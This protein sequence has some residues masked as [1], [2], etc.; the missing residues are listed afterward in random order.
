MSTPSTSCSCLVCGVPFP[1]KTQL[2]KHI[3]LKHGYVNPNAK[4]CK[5]GI[6]VGWLSHDLDDVCG[7]EW[8]RDLSQG[9]AEEQHGLLI[10]LNPRRAAVETALFAALYAA[11]SGTSYA[12]AAALPFETIRPKSF[13]RA[14]C[15]SRANDPEGYESSTHGVA[16]LFCILL[17]HP[18]GDEQQWIAKI[19][20]LIPASADVCVLACT[21]LP[22]TGGDFNANACCT[23]LRYEVI[24]PL[25][26][27]IP[28]EC[29]ST[30]PHSERMN[31]ILTALH[32]HFATSQEG[33]DGLPEVARVRQAWQGD[34]N[35]EFPQHT[36]E[37]KLR[38]RY[39]RILKKIMRK[40]GGKYI[41]FHNFVS[42]GCV[43][44]DA[45]SERRVDRFYH[46]ELIEHGG[47]TYVVMSVSGDSFL[48]GQ[49]RRI[50]AVT[51]AVISGIIPVSQIDA[52]LSK[53]IIINL[54]SLPGYHIYLSEA[55]YSNWEARHGATVMLD[56]RRL[57][58]AGPTTDDNGNADADADLDS[59][60]PVRTQNGFMTGIGRGA[61]LDSEQKQ[62]KMEKEE[63]GKISS[64]V[65]HATSSDLETA[66]QPAAALAAERSPD[67]LLRVQQWKKRVQ[68]HVIGMIQAA[69]ARG[70]GGMQDWMDKLRV[71]G[72]ETARQLEVQI[73]LLQ[74]KAN[75][76]AD[77]G[78]LYGP[79]GEDQ[80]ADVPAVYRNVLRLLRQADASGQWP[81]SS[82][83]RERVLLSD[84]LPAVVVEETLPASTKNQGKRKR[85]AG[86]KK[87]QDK[88]VAAPVP[89]VLS[90]QSGEEGD[91]TDA[92]TADTPHSASAKGSGS[93]SVG[94]L[95]AGQHQ[96]KGNALFPEL[97]VACFELERALFPDRA[98]SS[99]V[100]INRH[101]TFKPHRDSGAGNGQSISL[102]VSL[103][104]FT[105]GQLGVEGDVVDIRYQPLVFDGWSQRHWTLPFSGERFSLVWFTPLG[106]DVQ[107]DL[108][109]WGQGAATGEGEGG[110]GGEGKGETTEMDR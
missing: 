83:A 104:R 73:I 98:P 12:E 31:A 41:K 88:M 3:E 107:K 16:D 54:P 40:F 86:G 102:I 77:C 20:G 103:G 26:S 60:A 91:K 8:Q 81:N 29:V 27:L 90:A 62:E 64:E 33:G 55:K 17:N 71:V 50:M 15:R 65:V 47:E 22:G 67:N 25:N 18:P 101:A 85:P 10:R 108:F 72:Q 59:C 94:V 105:G 13:T 35:H 23:Q 2:F 82:L 11:Q 51:L 53:D 63:A 7:D 70:A 80:D 106:V 93:F 109:W 79:S 97:L 46:K 36:E 89:P 75:L 43:P 24:M 49:I 19:N 6:L 100:A 39:F 5:C 42:G 14:S 58:F 57:Y 1:S 45:S 69:N 21:V 68:E 96:P 4:P 76:E 32:D 48:R 9:T 30:P 110:G 37:G 34:M 92:T 28:P 56:P 38:V 61:A 44:D 66:A 95:P 74:N 87:Y 52:M 84:A 99:M 78:L